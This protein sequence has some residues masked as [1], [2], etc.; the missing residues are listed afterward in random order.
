[1]LTRFFGALRFCLPVLGLAILLLLNCAG[2]AGA[3]TDLPGVKNVPTVAIPQVPSPVHAGAVAPMP[4][5][6]QRI[7]LGA[8]VTRLEVDPRSQYWI[9][10]TGR[11]SIDQVH[12]QLGGADLFQPRGLMQ[13]HHAHGK[14]LWIRFEANITD[15][16]ARWF[17][18]VALPTTDDV[19]L[20]WRDANNQ[21]L[22]LRAGDVVPRTQWPILNRNP[23]FQLSHEQ[24]MPTEYYVRLEH[25]RVP[26]SAPLYIYRDTALVTQRQ[27]EYFFMGLYFGLTLLVALVSAAFALALRD[28]SF[29]SYTVYLIALGM[30]QL[31]YMGLAAQ[32]LWPQATEWAD[33][34]S[35]ILPPIAAATGLW[36]TRTVIRPSSFSPLLD[37]LTLGT[38]V[39]ILSLSAATAVVRTFWAFQVLNFCIAL[40]IPLVL[41]MVWAAWVQA[42]GKLRWIAVGFLPVIISIIPPLLRNMGV[43]NMGFLSQYSITIGSAL[44]MPI[45]LYALIVRSAERRITLARAVGLPNHDPLT[46]LSNVRNLLVQLHGAMTRSSR[47]KQQFA[48][49]LVELNNHDWFYNEH[50][51]EVAARALVL[52]GTRLQRIAREVDTVARLDITQFVFLIEGPCKTGYAAKVAAQIAASGHRPS[53]FLPVGA[54]LKLH[55]TCALMPEARASQLGDDANTQLAW[56]IEQA[57]LLTKQGTRN[58][59][60][61]LNF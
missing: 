46:G 41:T 4:L 13:R 17:L 14:V 58:Q 54:T 31:A 35:F 26:F 57:D 55:V 24:Q 47:F 3:Q 2:Q 59:V 9:D 30:F 38:I 39:L 60:H 61:T 36:F 15:A 40:C 16:R 50:G 48:M 28:R 11:A 56:L 34:A 44:E 20:F 22:H 7:E 12:A 43:I 42:D 49:V 53:N 18:E 23:V 6:L 27:V 52:L 37:R 21:W 25:Q 51:R 32:Y 19:S 10:D 1:M 5:G 45:L 8:D 33:M 29:S